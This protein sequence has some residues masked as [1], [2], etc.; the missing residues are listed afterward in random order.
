MPPALQRR[1]FLRQCARWGVAGACGCLVAR[2]R[3]ADPAP[4][5][6]KKLPALE[7]R[8]WCGLIC[9]DWCPLY[10]A[11]RADDAAAKEKIY[12]EWKWKEKFGVEFEPAQVFCHGC[13]VP[14]GKP[15]NVVQQRCT[16]LE[17]CGRRGLASCLQ[18]RKLAGCEQA[19]WK[20]Y[21]DFRRQMLELQRQYVAEGLQLS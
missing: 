21:P 18:C 17:C 7:D 20:D 16:V 19:L 1:E 11:T 2:L 12:R 9:G 13:R 8:A 4:A 6:P 10:K 14:A 3:A 5:A 15:A